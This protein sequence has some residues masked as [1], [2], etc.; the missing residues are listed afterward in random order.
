MMDF[1]EVSPAR[2]KWIGRRGSLPLLQFS[3]GQDALDDFAGNIGEAI[4]AT[5][6]SESQAGVVEAE[7]LQDGGLEIVHEDGVV[8]DV[9]TVIVGGAVGD[10]WFDSRAGEPHGEAAGVM[11]AAV[12]VPGEFALGIIGPAEFASPHRSEERRV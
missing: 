10:A 8:G 7:L 11:I 5:L 12:V 4:V 9:V 2:A 1:S 3:S 6:E